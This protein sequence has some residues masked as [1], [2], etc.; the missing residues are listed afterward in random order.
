MLLCLG[1]EGGW[2]VVQGGPT[3]SV[4]VVVV[5]LGVISGRWR[6]WAAI[7]EADEGAGDE[8]RLRGC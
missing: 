5:E 2:R 3:A 7:Q 4:V 1:A 6:L 8:T